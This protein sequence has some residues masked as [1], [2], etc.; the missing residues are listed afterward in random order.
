MLTFLKQLRAKVTGPCALLLDNA[1]IHKT[2]YIRDYC[3]QNQFK[4]LWLPPYQPQFQ[5]IELTWSLI[6]QNFKKLIL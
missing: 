4:M 1:S 6:K 2:R 3:E 5:P